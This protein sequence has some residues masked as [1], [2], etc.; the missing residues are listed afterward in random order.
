MTLIPATFLEEEG[1]HETRKYVW[2][3]GSVGGSCP[4]TERDFVHVYILLCM[5]AC[6]CIYDQVGMSHSVTISYF[7]YVCVE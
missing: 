6:L 4:R 7:P 2:N 3:I 5:C 1:G